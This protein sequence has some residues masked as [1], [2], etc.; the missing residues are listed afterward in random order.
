MEQ[1]IA[2]GLFALGALL[3]C[4]AIYL[5]RKYVAPWL[6]AKRAALKQ[7]VGEDEYYLLISQI[8]TF[9]AMAEQ[10]IGAGNGKAKSAL[11]I[12]WVQ[13]LFPELE[14]DYIQAL[15]DGFMTPLQQQGIINVKE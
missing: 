8:K 2:L 1:Y 10:Q 9:M 3:G 15:I 6:E 12:S 7:Q 14:E 5:V 4:A 11:V 13:K